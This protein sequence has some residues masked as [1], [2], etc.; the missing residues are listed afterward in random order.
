MLAVAAA[1]VQGEGCSGSGGICGNHTISDPFWLVDTETG[2]SCAS[3]SP[4]FEVSCYNNALV[5]RSYG[6]S[7]FQ[8]ASITYEEHSLRAIDLGKLDLLN[9][10]NSCDV[11]PNWNTSAKLARSFQIS[12][13]NLNLHF[14][15]S[16]PPLAKS[17]LSI[18]SERLRCITERPGSQRVALDMQGSMDRVKPS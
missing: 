18:K 5:L 2:S 7:G 1:E 13:V 17:F 6:L 11:V 15:F 9:V 10:S 16:A 12:N 14:C 3:G 8:I 4:Y